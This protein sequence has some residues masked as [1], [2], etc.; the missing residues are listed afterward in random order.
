MN[1][2]QYFSSGMLE[3]R[4]TIINQIN[5]FGNFF[6]NMKQDLKFA[7]LKLFNNI[8]FRIAVQVC[9]RDDCEAF[10]INLYLYLVSSKYQSID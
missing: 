5:I 4:L 7:S 6:I 8:L 2:Y 1:N 3:Y 10:R 9:S